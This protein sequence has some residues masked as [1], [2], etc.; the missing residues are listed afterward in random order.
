MKIEKQEEKFTPIKLVIETKE[1]L[2]ALYI[3][4]LMSSDSF[5]NCAKESQFKNKFKLLES[6]NAIDPLHSELFKILD[7][8]LK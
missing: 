7:G 5:E 4:S 8:D 3:L 1:E 6:R 2:L